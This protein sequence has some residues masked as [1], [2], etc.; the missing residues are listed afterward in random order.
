MFSLPRLYAIVD[1][2]FHPEMAELVSSCEDLRAAGCELLQ[3]RNKDSNAR[4]VLDQAR[5]LRQPLAPSVKLIMND[6]AD[7]CL[8]AQFDG[9]HVG[10]ADLLPARPRR[11]ICPRA[12]PRVATT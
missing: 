3:Y 6:R 10:Q 7:L 12:R 2:S 4:Q 1:S 5:D 8:A 11:C 9:A